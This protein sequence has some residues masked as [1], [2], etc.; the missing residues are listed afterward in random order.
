MILERTMLCVQILELD[1]DIAHPPQQ[2]GHAG[3]LC[4]AVEFIH[5]FIS[6]G[7]QFQRPLGQVRRPRVERIGQVERQRLSSEERRVGKEWVSP[8][9]SRWSPYHYKKKQQ[10]NK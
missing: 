9:R 2:R 3:R 10:T 4:L 1:A 7:R 8:C 5:Q 6:L